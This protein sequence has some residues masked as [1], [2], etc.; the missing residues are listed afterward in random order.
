MRKKGD[1]EAFD[2]QKLTGN[3]LFA[4]V[5]V[6]VA[7]V[8]PILARR[9]MLRGRALREREMARLVEARKGLTKETAPHLWPMKGESDDKV[10]T[11]EGIEESYAA[12]DDMVRDCVVRVDGW[13]PLEGV[14][15]RKVVAE[16]VIRLAVSDALLHSMMEVQNLRAAQFPAPEGDGNV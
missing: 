9:W 7:H 4:G 16:E 13:E 6:H 8:G 5:T 15:D 3:D 10:V 12:S 2:L 11:T 1:T 14:T